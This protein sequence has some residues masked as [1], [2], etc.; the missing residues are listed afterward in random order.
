M[1]PTNST[2]GITITTSISIRVNPDHKS[3][4]LSQLLFGES[5]Q[6]IQQIDDW[7][8]INT[9]P[10]N[11]QGWIPDHSFLPATKPG[12]N[13]GDPG[14]YINLEMATITPID[15]SGYSISVTPGSTLPC[16][17]EIG[18]VFKLGTRSFRFESP[19]PEAPIINDTIN[20]QALALIFIHSPYLWGGRCLFGIDNSGLIQLVYKMWG[21][22]LPGNLAELVKL[23]K[24]VGFAHDAQPGDLA[25]F[26]NKEGQ[27]IHAGIISKPNTIIHCYGS[28]RE[29][30][31]D[32]AGIYDP[33]EEKYLFYLRIINRLL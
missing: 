3:E 24:S 33:K 29:D 10:V 14:C 15:Y 19:V 4:L 7:L 28:V 16:Q 2:F 5:F 6:I 1:K 20:M 23:G 9:L 13:P 12:L 17:P 26:E 18:K 21:I 22:S 31:L 25:F 8:L 32:H 27:I 11:M 30:L